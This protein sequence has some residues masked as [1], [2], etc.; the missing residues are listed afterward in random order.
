MTLDLG[1]KQ[2]TEGRA[3]HHDLRRGEVSK[4]Q[5]KQARDRCNLRVQLPL[6]D[7]ECYP[8]GERDGR[9]DLDSPLFSPSQVR[10]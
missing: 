7:F 1:S 6:T 5:D 8:W 10:P 9:K 3:Q 2:S 4:T